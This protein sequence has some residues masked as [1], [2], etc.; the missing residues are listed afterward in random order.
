[1]T[2]STK[3]CGSG[4]P[5]RP[6]PSHR[7]PPGPRSACRPPSRPQSGCAT[8]PRPASRWLVAAASHRATSWA[9]TRSLFVGSPAAKPDRALRPG[10]TRRWVNSTRLW[11]ISPN[12]GTRCKIAVS[13][14]SATGLVLT[15]NSSTLGTSTIFCPR[16][17]FE[18][19]HRLNFRQAQRDSQ[20]RR[21]A[22]QTD[23]STRQDQLTALNHLSVP[24]ANG[25]RV[26]PKRV[27]SRAM[28]DRVRGAAL[29]V[30]RR[31][32]G[33]PTLRGVTMLARTA[34]GRHRTV[35]DLVTQTVTDSSVKT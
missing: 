1:M 18:K 23:R 34:G 11:L 20:D 12:S 16:E 4:S 35:V 15:T 24:K 27:S 21:A 17:Q 25:G 9:K 5:S 8:A 14:G 31:P 2:R 22:L 30:E 13:G 29:V 3:R 28:A 10:N 19:R 26:G 33:N 32:S 7:R 6:S